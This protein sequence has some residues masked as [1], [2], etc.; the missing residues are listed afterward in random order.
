VRKSSEKGSRQRQREVKFC[1]LRHLAFSHRGC[2]CE[3]RGCG[4]CGGL[5]IHAV[6]GCHQ[7]AED[8]ELDGASWTEAHFHV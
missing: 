4:R 8:E 7:K 6:Q 1:P 5:C 2:R 3:V